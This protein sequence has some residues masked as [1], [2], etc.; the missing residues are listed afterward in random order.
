MMRKIGANINNHMWLAVIFMPNLICMCGR[1]GKSRE[2]GAKCE[3][4]K[5]AIQFYQVIQPSKC[6][7]SAHHTHTHTNRIELRNDNG[8]VRKSFTLANAAFSVVVSAAHSHISA[9]FRSIYL[10]I[11]HRF[12]RCSTFAIFG[13]A[14]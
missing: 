1:S 5:N 10:F 14:T 4:N 3:P 11:K 2:R 13:A 7:C 8:I 9:R 6:K 12:G